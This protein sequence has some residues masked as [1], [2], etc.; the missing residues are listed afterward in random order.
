MRSE[1]ERPRI[2]LY[3][4][5]TMGLG[6]IRRNLLLAQKL[7]KSRLEPNV[8]LLSGT[9][10]A[11]SFYMP[12]GVDCVTLPSL[13]KEQDG[14]YR[15]RMLR[16]TLDEIIS[17]RSRM[18]EASIA[19]FDPHILI[20]DTAPWGAS[21]EL[22]ATLRRLTAEGRTWRVLGMRDVWDEPEAIFGEWVRKDNW[23]AIRRYYDQVF[24]YGD[25]MVYDAVREYHIEDGIASKFRYTGYLGREADS[26][27]PTTDY[28]EDK[29]G[30]S[31]SPFSLCLM[32]GGQDGIRLAEA[33]MGADL[34]KGRT[35]LVITGPFMNPKDLKRLRARAARSGR[36]NVIDFIPE[37][38][39]FVR[40]AESIVSM[41]GY[42]A[43]CEIVSFRKRALIVPRIEP[44][45]EQLIRAERL[46]TFGV[47]EVLH[48]KD[49]GSDA[50][51]SFLRGGRRPPRPKLPIDMDG[52]TKVSELVESNLAAKGFDRRD[53]LE[54]PA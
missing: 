54:E 3:S 36:I 43:V 38:L 25:P 35:G 6:H 4:H 37:P 39:S 15:S 7:S 44:R 10:D 12:Q 32:G 21:G 49:L 48:P 23:E 20:V 30:L 53:R 40:K 22:D 45:K 17:I 29:P 2:A 1:S 52:L 50:I 46:Q 14:R 16:M 47:L 13:F 34:P 51:T 31:G 18:L 11:K 42:N 19:A 28:A 41:G 26:L 8:L 33:F 27:I 9:V 5:D 24:V